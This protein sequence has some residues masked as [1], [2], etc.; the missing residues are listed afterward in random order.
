MLAYNF[1]FSSSS[2]SFYFY[3][4]KGLILVHIFSINIKF[5]DKNWTNFK[6]KKEKQCIITIIMNVKMVY[7]KGSV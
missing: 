2:T 1:S 3:A 6:I 4:F 5:K 7:R